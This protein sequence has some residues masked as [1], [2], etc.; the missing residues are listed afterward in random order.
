[1]ITWRFI[2]SGACTA[3]YNMAVD[4]AIAASVREGKSPATLRLYEWTSPSVSIGCFQKINSV[5]IVY[6][7]ENG[8]PVVRRLTGGRAI[9]HNQELTYSFSAITTNGFFSNGLRDS[10]KKISDAFCSA[11]SMI[12]LPSEAKMARERNHGILDSKNPLCFHSA[13][14]GEITLDNKKI[15]GSAQKRWKDGLLQQ[16]S[17]PCI[18]DEEAIKKVFDLDPSVNLRDRMAGLREIIQDLSDEHLKDAIRIAFENTFRIK[19]IHSPLSPEEA[20]LAHELEARK[21][22]SQ[23]WTFQKEA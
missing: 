5:N 1:M 17:I 9:L 6:C 10:Y 3:S 18:I 20:R 15:I 8:I 11:I 19:F 21:Y 16:G 4:E 12:G 14:F 22:L 2:D 7:T 13:S 23:E